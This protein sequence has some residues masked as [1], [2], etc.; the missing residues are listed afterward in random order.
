MTKVGVFSGTFDP[1]HH[2]HLGI[3]R[4]ALEEHGLERVLFVP[5]VKPRLKHLVTPFFHRWA[6]LELALQSHPG[7][8][9][10]RAAE[11]QHDHRTL[12]EIQST[13]SDAELYLIMGGDILQSDNFWPD[14]TPINTANLIVLP[15]TAISSADLRS[16]LAKQQNASGLA[17]AVLGYIKE[18][19]L[20]KS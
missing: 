4:K 3:A 2:G 8:Y 6:M 18:H 9:L 17:E 12:R 15:R 11:I 16:E 13:Y 10:W 7:F 20:Y 1:V 14:G 19:G 5:E